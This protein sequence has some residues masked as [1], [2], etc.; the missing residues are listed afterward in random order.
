MGEDVGCLFFWIL[1][2]GQAKKSLSPIKG[3]KIRSIQVKELKRNPSIK[4]EQLAV[5]QHNNQTLLI[6]LIPDRLDGIPALAARALPM[7]GCTTK[8]T[9]F[10]EIGLSGL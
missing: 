7:H 10:T 1:F 5:R 8:T 9:V 2:F 4:N 3:E 6:T